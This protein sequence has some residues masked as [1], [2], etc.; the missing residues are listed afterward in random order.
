V[1]A[2]DNRVIRSDTFVVDPPNEPNPRGPLFWGALVLAGLVVGG[3][4]GIAVVHYVV[5]P[6]RPT[7]KTLPPIEAKPVEAKPVEAKP[8]EAKPIEAKPVEAK[9]VEAKP[10]EAKPVEVKPVEVKPV[11]AN[12]AEPT[13]GQPVVTQLGPCPTGTALIPGKGAFCID[14]YEYP[15]AKSLPRVG[16]SFHDAEKLCADRGERLCSA[17]EWEHACR[18]KSGAS[19]PYGQA[20]EPARCNSGGKLAPSGA[21]ASCRSAAGAYDMSGNAAEW[22]TL[23]GKPA[24]KGGSATSPT[25]ETRCSHLVKDSSNDGGPFVGFRCC[26]SAL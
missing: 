5:R 16:V 7:V 3:S 6:E 17:A 24:R 10:V 23:H 22:V 8:I 15:G 18:G 14:L 26:K 21:F 11:E 13:P 1:V 19:Y 12:P 4:A 9:P 2:P 20:F 25:A